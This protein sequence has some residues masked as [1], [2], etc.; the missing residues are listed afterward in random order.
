[1]KY[2]YRLTENN[3]ILDF[4]SCDSVEIV[5]A[6]IKEQYIE[7]DRKIIELVDGRFAFEDEVNLAEEK[8]RRV[9]KEFE[10][11]KQ[12]KLNEAGA[13]FAEQRDKV[14]F[15]Q[16]DEER[17]YGFD[18]ANEDVTNFMASYIPLLIT[19]GG[20]TE[21]K[22]YLDETNLKDKKLVELSFDDMHKTYLE[23]STDQKSAYKRYEGIVAQINACANK[24]EL[25]AIVLG[26]DA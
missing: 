24:G 13:I 15:I 26:V 16:L 18:C 19:Q 21:Y 9:E 8:K 17:R 12:A 3:T 5:P 20:I 6:F 25:E 10:E 4:T 14:R 1:M 22:V 23:V 2:F 11:A 7:T